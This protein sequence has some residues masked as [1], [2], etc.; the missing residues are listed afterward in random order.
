MDKRQ[1][2]IICV[3]LAVLIIMAGSLLVIK[4]RNRRTGETGVFVYFID[5]DPE[6]GKSYLV[7]MRREI[8]RTKIVEEKIRLAMDSLLKG[9]TEKEKEAGLTNAVSET[10]VLL[11]V[12]IDGDTVYLDFSK[13]IER[14]GGT[15]MMTDRLAQIIFTATQFYP[16][17][18]I[19]LLIN[20]KTIKYFSG[21]GIT[22]VEKPMDRNT[23]EYSV[24]QTVKEKRI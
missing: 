6:A 14:G 11:N 16:V 15:E 2:V 20:G 23:F 18:K 8:E 19:Q 21:E 9:L 10:A 12:T 7:P 5:Y 17:T 22:D 4:N 24:R 13:E 3:L 1:K